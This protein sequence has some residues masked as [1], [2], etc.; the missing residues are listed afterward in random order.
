MQQKQ[1]WGFSWPPVFSAMLQNI[2]QDFITST[3]NNLITYLTDFKTERVRAILKKPTLDT[4]DNSTTDTYHF[5]TFFLQL[6][7]MQYT[8][9]LT[10]SLLTQND[11]QDPTSLGL[12]WC[13]PQKLLLWLLMRSFLLM[14]TPNYH[15]SSSLLTF[16]QPSTRS[17]IK[18]SCP[19]SCILEL[20]GEN[21]SGLLFNWR[22]SHVRLSAPCKVSTNVSQSS[23]LGP[24]L[25][26]PYTH[27]LSKVIPLHVLFKT[28]AILTTLNS[29]S[30]FL[31]WACMCLQIPR[32][33]AGHLIKDCSSLSETKLQ[34]HWA[35]VYPWR[36]ILISRSWFSLESSWE[37]D[38]A[39][40]YCH[41]VFILHTIVIQVFP[42][43]YEDDFS[44]P[45]PLEHY[46]SPL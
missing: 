42:L 15:W 39:T 29:L 30:M 34:Q 35:A 31:F 37:Y 12:K 6:L 32:M 38:M 25:F 13:T 24:L 41:S 28:T 3:I 1:A 26:S 11:L 20:M 33:S 27:S 45:R 17:I 10:V 9:Q 14:Y 22:N 19:S 8:V 18:L 40:N 7:N 16:Q 43:K 5:L 23:V 4:S 21:D 46:F 44:P 36:F 2:W